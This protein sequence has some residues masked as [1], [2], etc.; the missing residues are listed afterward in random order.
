MLAMR[1]REEFLNHKLELEQK[2]KK[3]NIYKK[4]N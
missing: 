2:K 4:K 3:T 1:E